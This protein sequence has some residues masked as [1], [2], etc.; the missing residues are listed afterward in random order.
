VLKLKSFRESSLKF[1]P[2]KPIIIAGDFNDVPE[3]ESIKN[4]E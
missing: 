4:M 3:S 1:F 2:D